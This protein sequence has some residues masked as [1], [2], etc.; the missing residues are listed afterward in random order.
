MEKSGWETEWSLDRFRKNTVIVK[1]KENKWRIFWV[2][3]R[4]A[5]SG[6]SRSSRIWAGVKIRPMFVSPNPFLPGTS[7]VARSSN[8]HNLCLSKKKKEEKDKSER[9]R[10]RGTRI[11]EA[12]VIGWSEAVPSTYTA[13]L[14]PPTNA[15]SARARLTLTFLPYFPLHCFS[16]SLLPKNVPCFCPRL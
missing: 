9:D 7:A 1:R 11:W 10:D 6:A 15:L 12:P 16:L 4:P 13:C 8:C 5:N 14:E 2:V 3:V